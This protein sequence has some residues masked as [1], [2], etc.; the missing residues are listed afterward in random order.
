MRLVTLTQAISRKTATAPMSSQATR[1]ASPTRRSCSG[2]TRHSCTERSGRRRDRHDL[3]PLGRQ[4]LLRALGCHVR[5]ESREHHD[6]DRERRFGSSGTHLSRQQ[7][8]GGVDRHFELRAAG[9]R[10]W[11]PAAAIARAV[12]TQRPID[13]S[14]IGAVAP[15]PQPMADERHRRRPAHVVFGRKVTAQ[16]DAHAQHAQK[17][18][19]DAAR[20]AR[21]PAVLRRSCTSGTATDRRHRLERRRRRLPLLHVEPS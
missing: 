6:Q 13:H 17:V 11:G 2:R 4:H 12:Q 10:G 7:D 21:P 19:L 3:G 8:V 18:V 15:D 1:A 9:R 14:R 16:R 20:T 5:P